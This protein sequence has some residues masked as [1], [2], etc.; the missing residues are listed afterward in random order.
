[1]F[2]NVEMVMQAISVGCIK[3][4]AESMISKYNL[5]N[6]PLRSIS[7]ET[8]QDEMF[9]VCF[10]GGR[11]WKRRAFLTEKNYILRAS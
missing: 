8:A 5:H 11:K 9:I 10:W 1:M 2:T 3:L 6:T 7:E 4:S